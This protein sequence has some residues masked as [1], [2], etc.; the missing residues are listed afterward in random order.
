MQV[1][2][3]MLAKVETEQRSR[4]QQL[5]AGQEEQRGVPNFDAV[6]KPTGGFPTSLDG[7]DIGGTAPVPT[8]KPTGVLTL[9]DKKRM[10]AEREGQVGGVTG[11]KPTLSQLGSAPNLDLF[12]TP[13][14]SLPRPTSSTGRALTPLDDLFAPSASAVTNTSTSG[15]PVD[16]SDFLPMAGKTVFLLSHS[17][18]Y[19][20]LW[21][22]INGSY[23]QSV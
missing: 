18:N 8:T 4:L 3:A 14:P 22:K 21:P 1:I 20:A 13:K 6:L 11:T 17:P 10:A 15:N 19:R 16:V 2:K 7:L 12:G 5:S 23:Q 9:E